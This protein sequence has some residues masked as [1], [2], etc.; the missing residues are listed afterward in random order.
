[1]VVC[2]TGTG[3]LAG[4][5]FLSIGVPLQADRS[6][7]ARAV[8]APPGLFCYEREWPVIER[9]DSQTCLG[10]SRERSCEGMSMEEVEEG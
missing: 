3:L 7:F 8:P 1:M 4:F 9:D 6:C 10:G 5:R 2:Q